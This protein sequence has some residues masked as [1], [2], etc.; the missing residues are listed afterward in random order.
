MIPV[1]LDTL[2]EIS[3]NASI[4][5]SF[6]F[7]FHWIYPLIF[8]L[9]PVWLR[10]IWGL[11][12]GLT[13]IAVMQLPITVADGIIIDF[14][15]VLVAMAGAFGGGITGWI[16]ML[17]VGGYRF[18]LGGTG[19]PVGIGTTVTALA[20]GLL[21]HR[22]GAKFRSQSLVYA[23]FGLLV[24][25]QEMLWFTALPRSIAFM[26]I[27]RYSL[28]TL[29]LFPLFMLLIRYFFADE[30][31]KKE[32]EVRLVESEEK[33]R[34]LVENSND[35]IFSCDLR[36]MLLSA[37]RRFMN[38]FGIAS[39]QPEGQWLFNL[40]GF[41]D[42]LAAW[43]E[44]LTETVYSKKTVSF[45]KEM[46]HADG[47]ARIYVTTLSPV[48]G[49]DQQVKSITGTCYDITRIRN[50]ER[51][52]MQLS[53]YD[54]L[55]DL[56][57]RKLLMEKLSQAIAASQEQETMVAVVV[58][59]LDNFKLIND[60]RGYAFGDELLNRVGLQLR[61][62][63]T[64]KDTLARIGED[65]FVLLF[66]HIEQLQPLMARIQSIQDGFRYPQAIGSEQ[67]HLK[68]SMGIALY[69]SDG[70]TCEEL[71]KNADTAMYKVK[72]L[73]KNHYRFYNTEMREALIKRSRL[74]EALRKALIH[75][76]LILQFQ[77]QLDLRSGRI[78]GFEALIRWVHPE[79]GTISPNDF[80]PV[81]EES[82]VIVPIGEWVIRT[83]CERNKSIQNIG[84]PQSIISVNISAIQLQRPDFAEMVIG[85]LNETQLAPH[86][87]ELEITESIL[88]E[89]FQAAIGNLETLRDYGVLI[90]LDDFGTGYSSLSYLKRLPIGALKIDKSFVQ[91]I[92]NE[93][94]EDSLVESIVSLVHRMGI[95]VIAEGVESQEQLDCLRAWGCEY[96]QGYL[97]SKPLYE[98]EIRQ[99]AAE[100]DAA[101]R[102]A[103]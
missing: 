66:E 90:A 24:A 38:D 61:R 89:S 79:M 93:S 101:R 33:Y 4:F 21:V 94:V 63:L 51:H 103:M 75:N 19:M 15:A 96:A 50:S 74:E 64:P 68:L 18:Y 41:K 95:Q 87:L 45:E 12:F 28:P 73:G 6:I 17:F 62:Y 88:M 26:M 29:L 92:T 57:N 7:L 77:P 13:G 49:M 55:T 11:L 100:E 97:I 3:G 30:I 8:K 65:E 36:G 102:S 67:I 58:I 98:L 80:I 52:I 23:V 46:S 34:T 32:T 22:V 10:V 76:E 85:I 20:I 1:E 91:D 83:A 54:T 14:R 59:D 42:N 39:G 35:S 44:L 48:I 56:P 40:F 43:Q 27:S 81:A 16:A 31:H 5:L 2:K 60:T 86:D 84:Y 9:P 71:I 72:E 53:L 47:S 99:M 82:G 70:E 25:V 37:N 69:P 78:R